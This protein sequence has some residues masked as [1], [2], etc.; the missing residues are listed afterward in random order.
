MRA[1]EAEKPDVF[2]AQPALAEGT[3]GLAKRLHAVIII[4]SSCGFNK[5]LGCVVEL[6][7]N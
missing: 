5:S 3:D 2:S 4:P 7:G 1:I 6:I